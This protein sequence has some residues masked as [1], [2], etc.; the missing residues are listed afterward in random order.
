MNLPSATPP[1]QT[2]LKNIIKIKFSFSQHYSGVF[3]LQCSEHE[4]VPCWQEYTL[5]LLENIVLILKTIKIALKKVFLQVEDALVIE[6][7][8]RLR[9]H[10]KFLMDH[11]SAETTIIFSGN[12]QVLSI[13]QVLSAIY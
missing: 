12:Y 9:R 7:S 5:K 3:T 6:L 1:N 11:H 13:G 2:Q 10:C 4:L 8:I